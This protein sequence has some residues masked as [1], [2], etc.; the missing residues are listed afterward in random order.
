MPWL[1]LA[2]KDVI[3]TVDDAMRLSVTSRAGSRIWQTAPQRPP[4]ILVGR[5]DDDTMHRFRLSAL[6][7]P[8]ADWEEGPYSGKTITLERFGSD[9]TKTQVS[10]AI[11]FGIDPSGNELCL[12]IQ[13][14]GGTDTV[15]RV[16]HFY[17]FEKPV[18]DG[19]HLILPHGSG[20]LIPADCPD[21]LPGQGYDGG[22]VGARWSL[23][24]FGM[25][26]DG[27]GM[28]ATVDSWWDCHVAAQHVPGDRSALDVYWLDSLGA[29][30]YARRLRLLFEPGMDYVDMAKHYRDVAR[31]QGLLRTLDEKADRSAPVDRTTRQVHAAWSAWNADQAPDVV[32]HVTALRRAGSRVRFAFPKWHVAGG[33]P[34]SGP[35]R[36]ADAGWQ[37]YLHDE[38]VPGGWPAIVKCAD[39]LM[40]LGSTLEYTVNMRVQHEGAPAYDDGRW[41]HD[42]E[43]ETV[44]DLSVHD[45]LKRL[46]WVLDRAAGHGALVDVLAFDGFAAFQPLRDDYSP[47]HL[48]TRRN[49]YEMQC[50]CFAETRRRGIRPAGELARFWAMADCGLFRFTDWSSDR[51]SNQPNRHS[52]GPVGVPIPLFQL[53]FNDCYSAGLPGGGY[54]AQTT[55]LDWWQDR[56]PR[57]YELLFAASPSYSWL[58]GGD[59]PAP[60]MDAPAIGHRTEWLRRWS[61]FYRRIATSEMR[62]HAFLSD[63]RTHQRVTF[64]N[65]TVVEI[66]TAGNRYRVTGVAGFDGEWETAPDLGD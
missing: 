43:G 12:E 10:L 35:A 20:Y 19:G 16:E 13:Q 28:C 49:A 8:I 30:A 51:L 66:D 6:D 56:T 61:R 63:D 57:L 33:E 31:G 23:P 45:A 26:K 42:R 14:V 52:T 59:L 47:T 64:A 15:V 55:G 27:Q 29:L 1:E 4:T 65:G 40:R 3:V 36:A 53:V 22:L 2:G 9:P 21:E 34:D 62:A 41:P 32:R 60:D 7:A 17:R 11:R 39:A 46:G 25:V 37:A 54:A 5:H 48:V 18:S 38:P 24:I 50:A 44:H 58:P